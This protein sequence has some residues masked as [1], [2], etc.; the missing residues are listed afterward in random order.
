MTYLSTPAETRFLSELPHEAAYRGVPFERFVARLRTERSVL[1]SDLIPGRDETTFLRVII[2]VDT[3]GSALEA[4]LGS[5]AVQSHPGLRVII[6]P[7]RA[8]DREAIRKFVASV[9]LKPHVTEVFPA[10][11]QDVRRH[12][13][14]SRMATLLHPGDRLHPSA[15]AWLATHVGSRSGRQAVVWGMLQPDANGKLVWAQRNPLPTAPTIWHVPYLSN[16]FAV[17]TSLLDDYTG[18]LIGEFA[19]NDLHLFHIWLSSKTN[20]TWASHPEYF[21]IRGAARADF[22]T[23]APQTAS[24]ARFGRA[25]ASLLGE[26]AA[27]FDLIEHGEGAVTPYHLVPRSTPGSVSVVIPFRDKAELTLRAVRSVAQQTFPGHVEVILVNNGSTAESL[28][29]LRNGLKAVKQGVQCKI[30]DYDLPFN[31]SAQTNLGI[32]SSVGEVLVVFNN[33]CELKSTNA[34]AEMS[35]WA[36]RPDVGT[37]GIANLNPATGKFSSGMEARL[38]P[39]H[40]FDSIV[41]E[42]SA[43]WLTHHV[44]ST[45]G[46]TF[47]CAALSRRAY[48]RAGPLNAA[49][50]PNGYNDVEYICRLRAKRLRHV[51][52]G[53]L[54]ATHAPGQSRAS[55]DESPQKLLVRRLYPEVATAA[56]DDLRDDEDL[57]GLAI[58]KKAAAPAPAPAERSVTLAPLA[59]PAKSS[60]VAAYAMAAPGRPAWKRFLG[61]VAETGTVQSILARPA[62]YRFIRGLYRSVFARGQ[63]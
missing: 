10:F 32:D 51:T 17:S 14:K 56:L 52:L 59:G 53:H 9:K 61:R 4:T 16:A 58:K 29:T 60:P 45:F 23:A 49:V 28:K 6:I 21:L 20:V 46:N 47:A 33:D 36:V 2:P 43:L 18:D 54:H 35:A 24:F 30:V 12:L 13:A 31:H 25:Y 42:N 34:L 11:D 55:T 3:V 27:E 37:V 1:E 39:V 63:S 19:D 15:V 48:L 22:R 44:R 50:F 26:V 57:L 40:Y 5:L 8:A 38:N 41:E 7:R 62:A